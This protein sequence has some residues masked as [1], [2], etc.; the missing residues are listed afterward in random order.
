[1]SPL[2]Y[3]YRWFTQGILLLLGVASLGLGVT[4]TTGGPGRFVSPGLAVARLV[5]GGCYSWGAMFALA[6]SATII[7]FFM[8]YLPLARVGLMVEAA[9]FLFFSASLTL[10][11]FRDD[12]ASLTGPGTYSVLAVACFMASGV[13]KVIQ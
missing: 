7:G 9:G 6:G 4:I 2:T 1:M 13:A 3:A 12:H 5:P 8:H 10:S 11:V